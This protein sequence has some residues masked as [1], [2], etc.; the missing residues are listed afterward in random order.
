MPLLNGR[1][2]D[3]REVA[4]FNGAVRDALLTPL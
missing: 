4:K 1:N 2:L 3:S